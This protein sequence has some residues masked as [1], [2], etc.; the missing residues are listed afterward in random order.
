[1]FEAVGT[2]GFEDISWLQH[3]MAARQKSDGKQPENMSS[4]LLQGRLGLR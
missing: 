3:G 2:I 4:L 1:M